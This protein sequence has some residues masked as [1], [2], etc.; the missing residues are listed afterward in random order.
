MTGQFKLRR[1][2]YLRL[3]RF[4]VL[5]EKFSVSIVV[6]FRFMRASLGMGVTKHLQEFDSLKAL[7]RGNNF[8]VRRW[9]GSRRLLGLPRMAVLR[10]Y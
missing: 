4:D 7:G 5:E 6:I 1:K 9:F 3:G 8:S 2:I 10:G